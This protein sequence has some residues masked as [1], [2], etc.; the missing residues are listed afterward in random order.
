M[1]PDDEQFD[2]DLWMRSLR[3][4]PHG[5][6]DASRSERLR[7]RAHAELRRHQRSPASWLPTRDAAHIGHVLETLLFAGCAA[8]VIARLVFVMVL[9]LRAAA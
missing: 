7:R 3:A 4:L 9:L 2:D 1:K 5:D 8:T 6:L